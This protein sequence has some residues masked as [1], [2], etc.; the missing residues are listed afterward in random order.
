MDFDFN[1]EQLLLKDTARKFAEGTLAAT[2]EDDEEHHRFRPEHAKAMAE[3]GF[4]GIII[5]EEYGG[6]A[7]GHLASS[8]VSE[9]IAR[10]SAS[11]GVQINMQMN[12]PGYII[13][14][15]GTE[16]Q[17]KKYIPRLVSGDAFGCFAITEANTGSDVASMKTTAKKTSDGWL[18]NGSKMWISNGHIADI[19]IVYACT[20]KEAKHKGLSA[21]I[22]DM[23][24]T[25]GIESKAIESKF[26]LFCAP[27]SELYFEDALIPENAIL[28]KPGEGFKIC[29]TMLDCTRLSSAARAV[30][31]SQACLDASVKYALERMQFGKPIAE[32]QMIQQQIAQ[33]RVEHEAARLLVYQAAAKKDKGQSNTLEVSMAKFFGAEAAVYAANTAM[34]IHGSYGYSNEYPVGRYLRDAKSLQ[35]VEGTSNIQN[36]IISSFA[37][38]KRTS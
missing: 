11:W 3:L 18:L 23:K 38:G 2:Q 33:M 28:G 16:D 30:G 35:V 37:L 5:K 13:Q 24:K 17:K 25:K 1:E 20:D 8:I 10:V 19:G 14:T 29:M 26:G 15:F 34:K 36:M 21:F 27:T 32:Y 31:I 6:T 9:E 22:V 4:F 7:M 12:G